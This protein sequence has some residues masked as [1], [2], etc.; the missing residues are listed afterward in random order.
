MAK[1]AGSKIKLSPKLIELC[2]SPLI[3]SVNA[4]LDAGES[5][6]SVCKFVNGKGFKISTPLMY[7]YAKIRKQCIINSINIEHLIG[8]TKQ[9]D[10]QVKKGTNFQG[11]QNKLKSEIDAIDRVIQLGFDS[12]NMFYGHD[13]GSIGKPVP[14]ATMLA[15]IQLKNNLTEG[16]HGFLTAYG[17]NQLREVEQQKYEILFDTIMSFIPDELKETVQAKVSEAEDEYYQTT[18]YYEEYLRAKGLTEDEIAQRLEEVEMAQMAADVD[19]GD[20]DPDDSVTLK[21]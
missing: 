5:P 17:L 6:N 2:K 9:P 10:V 21:I 14:I 15:A 19:S 12:L 18:D 1:Q 7:E 3:D 13:E 20:S 8:V 4:M 16:A 11:R